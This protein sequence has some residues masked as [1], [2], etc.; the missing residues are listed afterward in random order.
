MTRAV[1]QS[2]WEEARRQIEKAAAAKKCWPCG[3]LH[4]ALGS[5]ERAFPSG[6]LPSDLVAVLRAAGERLETTRYDCRGCS[7]CFPALAVN[8]LDEAGVEVEDAC[9][10]GAVETRQGWPPLP[11][12]YTV[13]R[14]GA[15][16]AVCTLT[17]GDLARS[18]ARQAGPE[19]SLVDT[20]QT[21]NL[22]I[23]RVPHNVVANPNMRFLILCGEDSRQRIGH[24]PGQSFLAPARA[25][26]DERSRIVG[27]HGKRPVLHNISREAVEHFR[28]TVEIIDRVGV[29]EPATVLEVARRYGERDVGAAEP[30]FG[31]WLLG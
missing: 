13:L 7:V 14:F 12:D 11:G 16:V 3:C 18:I 25:G 31:K 22:G 23:E 6:S 9:R 29:V 21:E 4:G 10:N 8:A 20:L 27:A 26:L 5:I 19:I 2:A 24:L 28:R 1:S 15:P 30:F 17:S